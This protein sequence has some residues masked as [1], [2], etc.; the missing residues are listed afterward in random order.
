MRGEEPPHSGKMK[1]VMVLVVEEKAAPP[2]TLGVN[3]LGQVR[4]EIIG[5]N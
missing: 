3:N 5:A 4:E 1:E 2:K